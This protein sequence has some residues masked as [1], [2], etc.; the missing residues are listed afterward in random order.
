[1]KRFL[2]TVVV[3]LVVVGTIE[4][5]RNTPVSMIGQKVSD[6]SLRNV[7]GRVVSLTSYPNAKGF[8]IVFTCNHCP[9]A[10]LY[11]QRLNQLSQKFGGQ[12]VPLIAINPMDTLLYEEETFGLMQRRAEDSSYTF[13]Y[14]QDSRQVVAKAFGATHTPNAFVIWKTGDSWVVRYAGAIDDNGVEPKK[15]HSF[16]GSAVNELLLGKPVSKPKTESLGCAINYR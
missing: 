8:I 11:T 13:P 12:N 2:L 6:F 15:A 3:L 9:F 16:I 14:L 4:G 5:K 7:D 1:V 10:K